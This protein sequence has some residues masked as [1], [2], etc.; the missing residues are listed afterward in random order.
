M[1]DTP[2]EYVSTPGELQLAVER[3]EGSHFL[4]LDTEFVREK[5]YQARLCLLQV[6]DADNIFLVD[7][8]ALSS[9]APL[10]ELLARPGVTTVIHSARQDLE[11]LY[12]IQGQLPARLFD[13]QVA[14]V[15]LGHGEQVAYAA[16]VSEYCQRDLDKGATRTDWSKRPLDPHQLDYAADDVRYLARVY[17]QLEKALVDCQRIQ[18]LEEDCMKLLD[19]ALYHVDPGLAHLRIK[20][21]RGLT[22]KSRRILRR[23]ADWREREAIR[24]DLPRQW[25]IKDPGLLQIASLQPNN[26]IQLAAL[27][28]VPEAVIRRY[29]GAIVETVREAG[30]APAESQDDVDPAAPPTPQEKARIKRLKHLLGERAE[31]L[32]IAPGFLAPRRDL[33]QLARGQRQV[34]AMRGW[35]Q[36]VIGDRL[37]DELE[38][39]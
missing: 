7:V 25:I 24:R 32:G 8:L 3:L 16:L 27:D 33:E 38:S 12:Q 5:T 13:T 6:A 18:W 26:R 15:L 17:L 22:G 11:I 36:E 9:L 21:G 20:G 35:R 31:A 37:L 1:T 28:E 10:L 23:L 2:W 29:A 14:A 19:P 39:T 4:A 34:G 30:A